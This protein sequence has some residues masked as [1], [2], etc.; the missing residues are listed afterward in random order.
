MTD[1]PSSRVRRRAPAARAPAN[2]SPA[3]TAESWAAVLR[4]AEVDP[5]VR[6]MAGTRRLG[7]VQQ[8]RDVLTVGWK[9]RGERRRRLVAAIGLAVDFRTW[10]TLALRQGLD[11]DGAAA[12]MTTS[13]V[14]LV[15]AA[16]DRT[17][18][19]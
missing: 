16:A 8:A 2:R 10:E 14:G 12:L 7:Y 18:A 13:I 3:A 1:V 15:A 19:T 5:L 6:E 17:S 9:A 11:D 4:D